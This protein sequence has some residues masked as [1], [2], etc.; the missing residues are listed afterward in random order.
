[1]AQPQ[2]DLMAISRNI[3]ARAKVLQAATGP[4]KAIIWAIETELEIAENE[5]SESIADGNRYE[6]GY[7]QGWADAIRVILGAMKED[8]DGA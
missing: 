1:M 2:D 5:A 7:H 6:A 3:R 8:A 4:Q